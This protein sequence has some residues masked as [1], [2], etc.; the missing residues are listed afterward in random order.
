MEG[1][2]Y[3]EQKRAEELALI[4]K[5]SGRAKKA[6]VTGP[7]GARLLGIST[8]N[9][10]EKVDLLKQ[11]NGHGYGQ[12]RPYTDR[13]YRS[14]S[15]DPEQ[16]RTK[17]GIAHASLIR[18]FFDSF[19]YHGRMEALVQ[20]E[21]ARYKWN[22]LTIEELL[23]RCESLPRAK[24]LREFRRLIEYSGSTSQSPLET[25]ARDTILTAMA[26][27]EL[28][29][30]HTVEFQ[31]PFWIKA[32]DGTMQIARVDILING[33][34]VIELDGSIKTDGTFGD[35]DFVTRDERHRETELQN[36]SLLVR[37]AGWTSGRGQPLLDLIRTALANHPAPVNLP[38]R[39]EEM[40]P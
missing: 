11:G 19:R 33:Y 1:K 2:T 7:A 6:V 24:G 13:V 10:V 14:S 34:L 22:T 8:Y 5:V 20:I 9:W 3:R 30:V 25:L 31:I 16:I 21:S 37:R 23:K 32:R 40:A 4:R 28:P 18:C 27:G 17:D 15:I 12:S 39:A 36:Q 29:E 38:V 35:P 26:A